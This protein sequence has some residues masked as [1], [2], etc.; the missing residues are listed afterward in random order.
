MATRVQHREKAENRES[1]LAALRVIEG[2]ALPLPTEPR[3]DPA[4]Y[5][6]D[7]PAEVIALA[8]EGLSE[9]QIAKHLAVDVETLR[10]WGEAHTAL[11]SAL[12]RA[13]TA[14]LAWWEEKA[15][16]AIVTGDNRFP[17]GAWSQ[18]MRARF[19]AYDDRANVTLNFDLRTLVHIGRQEPDLPSE[20]MVRSANPLILDGTARL[21]G[22]QTA[23]GEVE[24]S[25]PDGP[26]TPPAGDDPGP[27]R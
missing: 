3:T 14:M 22:S 9:S 5:T 10:G 6:D 17:A 8:S 15:R 19:S 18:V 27:P 12:S 2:E 16:R 1:R 7:I 23:S 20:Q 24:S 11:K 25:S 4:E 13:R 26:P 21:V